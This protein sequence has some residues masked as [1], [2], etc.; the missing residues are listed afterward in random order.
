M[1]TER[2]IIDQ[3]REEDKEDYFNNISHD[4]KVLETFICNYA[5][6]LDS[7]DFSK[8][9]NREGIFAIR[10]KETGK[11]IGILT[12]YLVEGDTVE[13]GYGIGSKYWNNGYTTE[14]VK[15]FIKYLINEEHFKTVLASFFTNNLAS[16]RVMEK[17]G[18]VYSHTNIGELEYLGIS[19]DLVYYKTISE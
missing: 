19:R 15:V 7:F 2:L 12:K 6:D 11:L 16:K 17:V 13:I 10:L 14:A 3:I 9:L 4:K 5:E 18:M 1:T 8:Y